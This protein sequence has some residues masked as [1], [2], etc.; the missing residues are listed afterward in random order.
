MPLSKRRLKTKPVLTLLAILLVGNIFWFVLWL[1]AFIGGDELKDESKIIASVGEDQITHQQWMAEMERQAGKA[2]LQQMINYKVMEKAAEKYDI[3]VTDE[4]I[5]LEIALMLSSDDADSSLRQLGEE[6]LR[7]QIKSQLILEKVLT[8]DIVI[9]EKALKKYYEE[10]ESLYN[11]PTTY[12]TSLIVVDTK[13]EAESVIKELKGGSDF[14]VLARERSVDRLSASLGGDIGFV[15]K[16]NTAIDSA[17]LKAVQKM[18]KGD[19]SNPIL[20]NNGRYAVIQVNDK[21]EGQSFKFDEVKEHIKRVLAMEQLPT[22]ISPEA[23]WKEF[24][25]SWFYG[26]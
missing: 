13:S 21:K 8:K 5:E 6:E 14:E 7:E 18:K 26:D 22:S 4:E 24:D 3:V 11:I 23:F 25:V 2:V 12:R 10:N 15:T 9:K 20:L 1:I 19:L 16:N 17:I